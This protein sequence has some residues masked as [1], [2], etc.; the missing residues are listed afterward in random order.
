MSTIMFLATDGLNIDTGEGHL[1]VIFL[2][3]VIMV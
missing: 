2:L 3:A 1:T